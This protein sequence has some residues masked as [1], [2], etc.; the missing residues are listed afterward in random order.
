MDECLDFPTLHVSVLA[1]Y[2]PNEIGPNHAKFPLGRDLAGIGSAADLAFFLMAGL[3]PTP[4]DNP[5]DADSR[6][7]AS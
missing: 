7:G 1:P 5:V 2:A 6:R 3:W 4:V